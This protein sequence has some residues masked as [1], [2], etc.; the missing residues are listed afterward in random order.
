MQ[1]VRDRH[2]AAL[3]LTAAHPM[4]TPSGPVPAALENHPEIIASADIGCY[5]YP[6]RETQVPV[7]RGTEPLV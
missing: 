2:V 5:A 4:G 7:V 3:A 6:R 1:G